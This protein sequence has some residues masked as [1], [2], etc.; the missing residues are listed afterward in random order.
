MGVQLTAATSFLDALVIDGKAF[1]DGSINYG[2]RRHSFT[3]LITAGSYKMVSHAYRLTREPRHQ[4][5]SVQELEA[6]MAI[7]TAGGDH[8]RALPMS[9]A[10]STLS[11]LIGIQSSTLVLPKQAKGHWL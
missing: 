6:L 3:A 1:T 8:S 9:E 2:Q 5:F 11:E 4:R 10:F 7:A